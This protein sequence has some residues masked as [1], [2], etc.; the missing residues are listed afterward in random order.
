LAERDRAV[1]EHA[2]RAL[3]EYALDDSEPAVQ[4]RAF[5][6]AVNL[7]ALLRALGRAHEA[8]AL[9]EDVLTRCDPRST[10]GAMQAQRAKL[11]W[12]LA[13]SYALT[14]DKSRQLACYDELLQS[15]ARWIDVLQRREFQ[16][17]RRKLAAQIWFGRLGGML[18]G[19]KAK[20]GDIR[21][22]PESPHE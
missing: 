5:K 20:K 1:A 16:Q 19:R 18:K 4:L 8:A 11:L 6:G 21:T 13:L 12:G 15:P 10:D 2:Y 22:K 7:N 14:G 3:L 17:E 9:S